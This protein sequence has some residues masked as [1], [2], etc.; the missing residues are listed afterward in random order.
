[1][2]SGSSGNANHWANFLECLRTR[3]R[4]ASDV[5]KCFRPTATYLLGNVALR[6]R[7]RLNWDERE[8]PG[9]RLP[10]ALEASGVGEERVRRMKQRCSTKERGFSRLDIWSS[11]QENRWTELSLVALTL[12]RVLAE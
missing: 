1:V 6:R 2:K 7:M 8:V 12:S 10:C 3:Q 9:Q 5:E 4:P 11:W